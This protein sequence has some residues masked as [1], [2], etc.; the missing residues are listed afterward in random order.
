MDRKLSVIPFPSSS[1]PITLSYPFFTHLPALPNH[2]SQ[3]PNAPY[4][5]NALC[6]PFSPFPFPD[7]LTEYSC[8]KSIPTL[9]AVNRTRSSSSIFI[10]GL[11]RSKRLT[12]MRWARRYCANCS[13]S[14][15]LALRLFVDDEEKGVKDARMR[16]WRGE[17]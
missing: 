12:Y 5:L 6:Q 4:R 3:L 8:G 1:L 16:F 10:P 15:I 2:S 7:G 9:R 11:Y 14:C 13:A 17:G